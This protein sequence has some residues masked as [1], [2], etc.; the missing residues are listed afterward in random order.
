MEGVVTAFLVVLSW[1]WTGKTEEKPQYTSVRL[2][3]YPAY[4]RTRYLLNTNPELCAKKSMLAAI[5]CNF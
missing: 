3:C 4:T 2:A 5:L 1:H